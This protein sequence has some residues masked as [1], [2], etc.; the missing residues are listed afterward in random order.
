MFKYTT[1]QASYILTTT[2]LLEATIAQSVWRLAMRTAERRSN[3]G[4][5]EYSAPVQTAQNMT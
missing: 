5:G 1:H 4:A 2:S 3:S